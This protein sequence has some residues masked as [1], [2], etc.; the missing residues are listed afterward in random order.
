MVKDETALRQN[1]MQTIC[2]ELSQSKFF[3]CVC[4]FSFDLSKH[5]HIR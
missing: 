3:V 1:D 4:F 5:V 2:G